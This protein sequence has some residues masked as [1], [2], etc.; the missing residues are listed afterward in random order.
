MVTDSH[1]IKPTITGLAKD[2][3][4]TDVAYSTETNVIYI[5]VKS[6]DISAIYRTDANNS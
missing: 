5:Q 4:I 1:S 2:A 6:G 3:E